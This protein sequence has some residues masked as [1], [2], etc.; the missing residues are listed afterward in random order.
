MS[1]SHG[2]QRRFYG[3]KRYFPVNF[4][5]EVEWVTHVTHIAN[6]VLQKGHIRLGKG[7][8]L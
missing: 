2:L 8:Y 7:G 3:Y 4:W 6:Y 1:D 5:I